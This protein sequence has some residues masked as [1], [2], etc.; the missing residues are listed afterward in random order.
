MRSLLLM[1]EVECYSMLSYDAKD[2]SEVY[3]PVPLHTIKQPLSDQE[4][5]IL[6]RICN[7][8]NNLETISSAG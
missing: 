1:E 6:K 4:I 5:E 2:F 7:K 8:T 3:V